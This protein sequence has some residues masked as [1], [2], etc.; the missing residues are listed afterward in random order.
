MAKL[1]WSDSEEIAIQL[2]ETHEDTNPLSVS[3]VQLH[4]WTCELPDFEDDP[5]ASSEGLLEGIQ[6]A[7]LAEWKYDNE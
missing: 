5:Q 7:W 3:F 4:R 6:M 1:R 2:Y